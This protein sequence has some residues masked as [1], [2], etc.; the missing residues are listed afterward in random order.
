[1]LVACFSALA[2]A[3]AVAQTKFPMSWN[4]LQ[5]ASGWKMAIL[6]SSMNYAMCSPSK[7]APPNY[8]GAMYQW[9]KSPSLSGASTKWSLGGTVPYADIFWNKRLLGDFSGVTDTADVMHKAHHFKYDLQ[10]YLTSS[11]APQALE[12]DINQFVGGRSY[13][14]GHECRGYLAGNQWDI[15]DNVGNKWRPTGVACYFKVNAW[16]HLVIEV[17]RTTDNRLHFVSISLNGTT[18]YINIYEASTATSWYGLTLNQQIDGNY[19]QQGYSEWTDH[20]NLYSW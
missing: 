19:E 6:P 12:F 16:N 2:G 15:W 14:W 20:Q 17:E 11:H 4:E 13:I 5:K 9:Q 10:F 7:C 18:K 3:S 8:W 1:M